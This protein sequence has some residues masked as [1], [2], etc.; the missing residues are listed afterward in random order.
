[1][2]LGYNTKGSS[3]VSLQYRKS[4]RMGLSMAQIK[5]CIVSRVVGYMAP[6]LL[7]LTLP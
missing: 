6:R 5:D 4:A 1:M 7:W 2:N 3:G